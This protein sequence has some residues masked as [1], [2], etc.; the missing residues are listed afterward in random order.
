MRLKHTPADTE[1]QNRVVAAAR[2]S[3][4]E[5]E[6]TYRDRALKLFPHICGRCQREFS[7]ARLRELTVHHKNHDHECNPADGSNWELLCIYCH[8]NEHD[9]LGLFMA[10]G[11]EAPGKEKAPVSTDQP[12][13]NL[14]ELL[15]R[16]PQK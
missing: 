4:A 10:T 2:A 8:E 9:R 5:R 11:A 12:F 7:G 16:K 3:Q 15:K 1:K 6:K 14:A 13:A